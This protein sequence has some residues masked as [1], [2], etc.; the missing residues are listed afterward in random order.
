MNLDASV[1][2]KFEND[3]K[4]ADIVWEKKVDEDYIEEFQTPKVKKKSSKKKSRSRSKDSKYSSTKSKASKHEKKMRKQEQLLNNP[5]IVL[6][7]LKVV[8][9][10]VHLMLDSEKNYQKLRLKM[11]NLPNFNIDSIFQHIDQ[12]M[13]GRL[14]FN[15]IRAWMKREC[16][17]IESNQLEKIYERW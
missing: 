10:F 9:E 16:M 17:P 3:L 8:S 4:S 5:E 14:T 13:H 6:A 11:K 12:K 2:M 15:Q 1:D 7:I